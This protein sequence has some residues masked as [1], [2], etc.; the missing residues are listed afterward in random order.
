M[1]RDCLPSAFV[2]HSRLSPDLPATRFGWRPRFLVPHLYLSPINS[3][4]NRLIE[5]ADH[6]TIRFSVRELLYDCTG[7][8]GIK[9]RGTYMDAFQTVYNTSS[10]ASLEH[11]YERYCQNAKANPFDLV[12]SPAPLRFSQPF[13]ILPRIFVSPAPYSSAGARFESFIR[14]AAN[15]K[16]SGSIA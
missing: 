4:L 9:S 1:V 10:R 12:E 16:G 14:C 11:G 13:Y 2:Q 3:D 15:A 6:S 5:V 7:Y 8:Q